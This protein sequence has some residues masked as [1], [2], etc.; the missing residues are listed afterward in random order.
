MSLLD[1]AN[2]LSILTK[3]HEY[4]NVFINRGSYLRGK[5]VVSEVVNSVVIF[6]SVELVTVGVSVVLGGDVVLQSVTS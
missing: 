3:M 1:L 6:S 5:G 4:K 2:N